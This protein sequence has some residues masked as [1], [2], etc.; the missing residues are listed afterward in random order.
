ML[1]PILWDFDNLTISFWRDGRRVQWTGVGNLVLH[2]NTLSTPRGLMEALLESF[3]D[4]F[5]EPSG[6]PPPW[7][8]D[9]RICLLPGTTLVAVWPYN[10]L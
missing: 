10:Y 8:H 6:L 2:C 7:R 5:T 4:I 1:G 9:H 3:E